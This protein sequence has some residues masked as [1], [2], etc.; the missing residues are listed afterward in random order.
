[1]LMLLLVLLTVFSCFFIYA[2]NKCDIKCSQSILITKENIYTKRLYYVIPL[3]CLVSFIFG[4]FF[5]FR[6]AF[7]R[8]V[9]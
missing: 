9:L 1:M 2:L 5:F 3:V 8:V 4:N 6:K 7:C